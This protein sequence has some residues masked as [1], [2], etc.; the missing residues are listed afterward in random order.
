MTG[1]E[2]LNE[3]IVYGTHPLASATFIFFVVVGLIFLLILTLCSPACKRTCII[4]SIGFITCFGVVLTLGILKGCNS[5]DVPKYTKYEVTIDEESV[6]FSEFYEK[7]EIIEQRG[8]IYI[9]KEK[10]E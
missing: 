9:I 10:K 2:F 7:Y 3:E 8:K 1:V 6:L 4:C 5:F